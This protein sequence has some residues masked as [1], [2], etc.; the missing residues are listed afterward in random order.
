MVL[1]SVAIPP[2]AVGHRAA[3]RVALAPRCAGL[4]AAAAAPPAP[5][6]PLRPGR[7]AGARRPVQRRPREGRPVADAAEAVAAA[8]AAGLAVGLISNQ[9]GVARGLLTLADVHG[10]NA[11]LERAVGPFDTRQICPHGPDDGCACRKPAPGMVL[12]AAESSASVRRT[13]W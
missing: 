9:S 1:T 7:H 13:A 2:V 12:A 11:E 6:D 10:V 8:R 3:R 4:A 5:G